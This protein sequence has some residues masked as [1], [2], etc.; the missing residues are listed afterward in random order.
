[1]SV[2]PTERTPT[3]RA[4]AYHLTKDE[5]AW[6]YRQRT[7]EMPPGK[8]VPSLDRLGALLAVARGLS[9]PIPGK[10]VSNALKLHAVELAGGVVDADEDDADVPVWVPPAAEPV[11]TMAAEEG[12]KSELAMLLYADLLHTDA[13]HLQPPPAT[14]QRPP[15]LSS[16][17]P[18][19]P[20][21]SSQCPSLASASSQCPS[22][23][24][25]SSRGHPV[26]P[27]SSQGH[28]VPSSQANHPGHNRRLPRSEVYSEPW[29]RARPVPD[30][31]D[32]PDLEPC[33]VAVETSPAVLSELAELKRSMAEMKNVVKLSEATA[34][35]S[36]LKL[37]DDLQRRKKKKTT[38]KVLEDD[39]L[40]K[41]KDDE[42][43]ENTVRTMMEVFQLRENNLA[44]TFVTGAPISLKKAGTTEWTPGKVMWMEVSIEDGESVVQVCPGDIVRLDPAVVRAPKP[45]AKPRPKP[46]ASAG[47]GGCRGFWVRGP[48][49][50]LCVA[51]GAMRG[52]TTGRLGSRYGGTCVCTPV[53]PGGGRPSKSIRLAAHAN[54]HTD[55]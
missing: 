27:A 40:A 46:K 23:P 51:S 53:E 1:M 52:E 35:S 44:P 29:T 47:M 2:P 6:I 12:R 32:L 17:G 21:A 50:R 48:K 43:R 38:D 8:P 30:L 26:P 14:S 25:A 33:P 28:P 24:S 41:R 15:V 10:S 9:K 37:I 7:M 39:Q 22:L 13:S 4:A 11:T 54:T 18:S 49:G 19:L 31:T 45:R 36:R 3:G 42:R 16:P 5:R 34:T 20:S 55:R